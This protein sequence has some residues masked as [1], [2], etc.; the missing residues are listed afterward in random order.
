MILV[1]VF[2]QVLKAGN[3]GA[4]GFGFNGGRN[5]FGDVV[6]RAYLG[7]GCQIVVGQDIV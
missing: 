6:G 7:D 2:L 4:G 1:P 5:I 3:F